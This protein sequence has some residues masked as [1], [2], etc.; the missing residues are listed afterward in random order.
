MI[1][2]LDAAAFPTFRQSVRAW[3]S[4]ILMEPIV[5]SFERLVIGVAVASSDGFH[6][7]MANA[8]DRLQCL[9]GAEADSLVYAISLTK[10]Q[11][12]HDL[13]RRSVDAL[14]EPKQ[15]ISG[16]SLGQCRAAEGE[17]LEAIGR[18]WMAGL[19]SLYRTPLR[20]EIGLV[21]EPANDPEEVEVIAYGNPLPRQV[22]DYVISRKDG[23]YKFFNEDIRD[24]RKRRFA[25]RSHEVH[26]DFAG[27]RLVANFEPI[28]P[29]RISG[30]ITTIKRR[31][32]DLKVERDRAPP[33]SEHRLHEMLVFTPSRDDPTL[34][35]KQQA[36][37]LE[38]LEALEEQADQ[39]ELRFRPLTSIGEIGERILA[40][41]A[42]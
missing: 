29:A 22:M 21:S 24:G 3:W 36:N 40:A 12:H 1:T 31:M 37:V 42:A 6:L 33:I 14:R 7:E 9:Y 2:S 11:L 15:A 35:P 32:W 39:E 34:T 27:S 20:D 25:G 10:E 13:A 8:L 4:P 18:N 41:E 23:Y 5:G 28:Q 26:I 30:S 38:A 19:S 17:T 16:I